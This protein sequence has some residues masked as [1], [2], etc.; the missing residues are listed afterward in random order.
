MKGSKSFLKV[1]VAAALFLCLA[2]NADATTTWTEVGDAGELLSTAQTTVGTSPLTQIGG[3]L[4]NNLDVDLFKIY[5]NDHANF[6]ASTIGGVIFDSM[7]FLFDSSGKFIIG[8]DDFSLGG[9]DGSKLS[10]G[11]IYQP[12]TNGFYYLAISNYNRNPA[13]TIGLDL[14][15]LEDCVA[16]DNNY[17]RGPTVA[18]LTDLLDH[19]KDGKPFS[20]APGV[21]PFEPGATATYTI[22]LEG[23]TF[24]QVPLPSTVL[25]LGSGLLRLA[26]YRRKLRKG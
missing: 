16:P 19:W 11:T 21:P 6:T 2:T 4:L 20:T 12:T 26:A 7:L 3:V 10:K 15:G 24:A 13:N 25:L 17:V 18:G 9:F 23:A 5:I 8:D 1:L 22:A 14:I